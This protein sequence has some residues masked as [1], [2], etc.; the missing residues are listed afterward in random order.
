MEP[1]TPE[2]APLSL[3]LA[4]NHRVVQRALRQKAWI[5]IL[6]LYTQAKLLMI[7]ASVSSPIKWG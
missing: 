3:S 1:Q 7:W 5:G 2:L 4:L 6:A